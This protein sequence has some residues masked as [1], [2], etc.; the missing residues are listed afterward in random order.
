MQ[1]AMILL[2]T[3]ARPWVK[4]TADNTIENPPIYSYHFENFQFLQSIRCYDLYKWHI[5]DKINYL[6]RNQQSL[7]RRLSVFQKT[8]P[9][10]TLQDRLHWNDMS[11]T[12]AILPYI[13]LIQNYNSPPTHK[14]SLYHALYTSVGPTDVTATI[15]MVEHLNTAPQVCHLH[16]MNAHDDWAPAWQQTASRVTSLWWSTSELEESRWAGQVGRIED[17]RIILLRSVYW[18]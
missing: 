18:R 14:Y 8:T 16:T 17:F 13:F 7:Y 9:F 2:Q 15:L 3:Y 10:S 11:N 1:A 6:P 12:V 5:L 4:P